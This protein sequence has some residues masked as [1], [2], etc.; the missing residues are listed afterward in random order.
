MW[1]RMK[2]LLLPHNLT[3]ATR[4]WL[5]L[6]L[7]VWFLVAPACICQA[8]RQ[9][10]L[11]WDANQESTL[12]GYRVFCRQGSDVYHYAQPV[13]DGSAATCI[14]PG[15][16]EYTDYAFVVR[17]YDL[18]GN[19]SADSDEVW[20]YGQTAIP[21]QPAVSSPEN[22]ASDL[23]LTPVLQTTPFSSPDTGDQ[24]LRTQWVV[25]R[26]S[27]G[28]CVLDIT[29]SSCL[30]E[31]D[32]PP[33]VLEEDTR[34]S[35]VARYFGAKGTL[36][37]WSSPGLFTTG[38]SGLDEDGNGVPDDQEVGMSVDLDNNTIADADQDDLRCVNV[39]EG[40]GQMAVCA[41]D[42]SGVVRISAL[43]STDL[44]TIDAVDQ[45]PYDLPLGLVSFRLEL[46]Q[47]GGIATVR[48]YFSEPAPQAAKWVK[49][50]IINGWQDYS[51]HAVF[52]HDRLSVEVEIQDGGFGDADGVENG[53]VIDPAGYGVATSAATPSDDASHSLTD[54]SPSSSGGGGG[55]FISA[56][57]N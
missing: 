21:G 29:S 49:H 17:A 26:V 3:S 9:V 40:T 36:S 24:H 42:G 31:L 56:L 16:D 37:E 14:L 19:Q 57:L 25:N 34:Y 47:T 39:L 4:Q 54:T 12:M 11:A 38:E 53:I 27:D 18:Y 43:E 52:A 48:V 7:L 55:C 10:T 50:D 51:A 6:V 28:L 22:D 35:W 1:T 15:L 20:L 32:V 2:L 33:L 45:I 41:P 5:G 8:S 13:W 46:D 30:T 44:V 23:F